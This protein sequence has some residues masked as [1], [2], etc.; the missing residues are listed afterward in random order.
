MIIQINRRRLFLAVAV[1]MSSLATGCA[2]PQSD[3]SQVARVD[4][5]SAQMPPPKGGIPIPPAVRDNLGITFAQ[6]QQRVVAE[7][8]RVPGQFE[9]LPTAR[10]EYR[11]VLG[12]RID[13]QVEQF[14][15]V[16]AGEVIFT[17]DSPQW[18]QVQ[19][20]AVEA[21]GDITMAQAGLEVALARRKEAQSS[22][23]RQEERLQNL[24]SVNVRNAELE[25]TVSILRNS[26]PRLDAETRALEAGLREAHEHYSSRLNALSSVTGF[27]IE[28]LRERNGVDAVWRSISVLAVRAQYTG[29]VETLAANDGGWLEEG[30]LALTI[31]RPEKIRFRAEAP[32]SDI[33]LY[34]EGQLASIVPPQ[35]S[36]V[37]MQS[38]LSGGLAL[39]LTANERDRT[40]SLYVTPDT[41]APWAKAGVGGF[42]EVTLTDEAPKQWAIPAS[43]VIQDGLEHVFYRRDP[44]DPDRALR[45]LADLGASDGRWIALKSGVKEGDEVVLD[46]VYAL[47]LTSS[48]QQAPPGYHY[49]A[50][51]G[52]HKNH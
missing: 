39:G 28:E 10:Q 15:T 3:Q 25:S 50:D 30:K 2:P 23:E 46:G 38:A 49:H 20:E 36:S 24:S 16:K 43:A 14:Q 21:E 44:K 7:T 52:L 9:L 8:R 35:G 6:V 42:L 33:T 41:I 5:A 29:I 45:V 12:G 37:D 13:L 26:L 17:I 18:R 32:Q 34:R 4:A 19:H 11:A 27:S 51:G 1:H 40:L 31:L 47:K 22:M 48:G